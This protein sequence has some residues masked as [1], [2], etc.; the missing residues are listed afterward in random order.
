MLKLEPDQEV[1]AFEGSVFLDSV[2]KRAAGPAASKNA[3]TKPERSYCVGEVKR[4][5]KVTAFS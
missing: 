4:T 1:E 2:V 5:L 3:R